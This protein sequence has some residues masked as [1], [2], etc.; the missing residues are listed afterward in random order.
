MQLRI[1]IPAIRFIVESSGEITLSK[2][3]DGYAPSSHELFVRRGLQPTSLC[4]CRHAWQFLQR[5]WTGRGSEHCEADAKTWALEFFG[6]RRL[7]DD[8]EG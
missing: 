7:E 6:V 3:V 5:G 2:S 4:E 8:F 1:P